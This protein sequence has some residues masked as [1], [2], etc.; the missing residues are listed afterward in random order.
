MDTTGAAPPNA[1]AMGIAGGTPPAK[2]STQLTPKEVFFSL[3]GGFAGSMFCIPMGIA[4]SRNVLRQVEDPN[5]LARVLQHKMEDRRRDGA[6]PLT[7]PKG[8]DENTDLFADPVS[9]RPE[10]SFAN[11]TPASSTDWST[12][13][14]YAQQ[15][16]GTGT[17]TGTGSRWDELRKD[18][19]GN[20]SVWEQIRQDRAKAELGTSADV[21]KPRTPSSQSRKPS[22][23]SNPERNTDY[24][25]AVREY[26]EAF[27]RERL[28]ID[29]TSGFAPP[30]DTLKL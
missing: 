23:T 30:S 9:Q 2:D 15:P 28:G 10:P 7:P 17:G 29:V 22:A 3:C 27:E 14:K 8:A 26:R 11:P 20:P 16:T 18:N 6:P 12:A 21:P 25:R 13:P 4:F 5:H 1:R 19:T 24:D